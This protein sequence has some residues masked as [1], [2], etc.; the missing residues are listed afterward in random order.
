MSRTPAAAD[1]ASVEL[2]IVVER[3]PATGRWTAW[4]QDLP[5]QVIEGDEAMTAFDTLVASQRDRLPDPYQLRVD[6]RRSRGGHIE[7]LMSGR[8]RERQIC[9]TCKGS[10]KY[11][12]LTVVEACDACGGTGSVPA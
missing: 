5:G 4:F 10:G 7:V 2:R 9:P 1:A 11:V 3:A 8:R 12:G 6:D